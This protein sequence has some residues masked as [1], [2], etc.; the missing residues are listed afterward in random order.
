MSNNVNIKI[1]PVL[2]S[3][4]DTIV[5]NTVYTENKVEVMI[6]V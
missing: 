6:V 4:V 5:N 3:K 2:E 1:T